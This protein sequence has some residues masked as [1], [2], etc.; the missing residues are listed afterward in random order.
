M[1]P[2]PAGATRHC[3]FCPDDRRQR[4]DVFLHGSLPELSRHRLQQLVRD[5]LVLVDGEPRKAG[6]RLAGGER[7]TVT[8]PP[9]VSRENPQPENLPLTILYE[10]SGLIVID[11]PAGMVVH[12]AAGNPDGT[13]VNALLHHCRD[14]R[15]IGGELRPGIVHRLD[16]NTSGVLV[17]A[18]DELCHRELTVQFASHAIDREYLAVVYGRVRPDSGTFTS[19]LGRS[20]RDRKKMASVDRGGRRAVTHYRVQS[21]LPPVTV[22]AVTLETGR[23]HQIRVHFTEAGHPLV[24]DQVYGKKGIERQWAGAPEHA[25]LRDFPRQA[26]HAGRLGFIHPRRGE[27][28]VFTAPPPVDML[29][30]IRRLEELPRA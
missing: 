1:I 20:P 13:L 2:P 15:G 28:L 12:P 26:L 18:K 29:E 8:V 16:Q 3:F 19:M 11:K 23:T 14:L 9:P 22:V 6:S 5:G 30:L 7:V 25:F 10:D 24:G 17:A 27:R 4:L 21:R